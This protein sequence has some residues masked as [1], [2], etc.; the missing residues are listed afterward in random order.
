[1]SAS[2]VER[3]LYVI[4]S[5]YKGKSGLKSFEHDAD[6]VADH[7]R[8]ARARVAELQRQIDK[9]PNAA[10]ADL[11]SAQLSIAKRDA[12]K[13]ETEL[14]G[15]QRG[16]S[17]A[18]KALGLL[19]PVGQ[20]AAAGLTSAAVPVAAI[21]VAA[22]VA[23]KVIAKGI[24][25]FVAGAEAVE[26]YQRATGASA[27]ESSRLRVAFQDLGIDADTAQQ[28]L[29]RLNATIA[30]SPDKLAA[31]G[32]AVVRNRAGQVD[33]IA[34]L[35]S[36]ADAYRATE[37]PARRAAIVQAAF[38]RGGQALTPILA[39]NREELAALFH[40]ADRNG[41]VFSQKDIDE[42]N[43]FKVASRELHESMQGLGITLGRAVLPV[44][45]DVVNIMT[46]GARET[47]HLL[48]HLGGLGGVLHTLIA[49]LRA[50]SGDM[51]YVAK[52]EKQ[53]A[54]A[55]AAEEDAARAAIQAAIDEAAALDELATKQLAAAQATLT[56]SRNQLS[57]ERASLSV[58]QAQQQLS[59][60][61][62]QA[63]QRAR[64]LS[65]A[66]ERVVDARQRLAAATE[67][68][69]GKQREYDRIVKGFG[70]DSRE[71]A[72]AQRELT[73]AT[74]AAQGASLDLADARERAAD[75]LAAYN[76]ARSEYG[77]TSREAID[78]QRGFERAQLDVALASERNTD[79]QGAAND[80]GKALND[81]V[82]GTGPASQKAKDALAALTDA[83]KA[84]R[85][86][87]RG[88]RDAERAVTDAHN[89]GAGAAM[90]RRAAELAL[91]EAYISQ[92]DTYVALARSVA[93]QAKAM[94]EA[95]GETFTAV[96][97]NERFVRTLAD[98]TKGAP[99]AR[100][101]LKSF[102]DLLAKPPMGPIAAQDAAANA[103]YAAHVSDRL[104]GFGSG[105]PLAIVVPVTLNGKVIAEAIAPDVTAIQRRLA[106]R[107]AASS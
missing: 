97:Y 5:E 13:L 19:G 102:F 47:N 56:G 54:D 85:D 91:R 94:A 23:I 39:K 55:Q 26:K 33:T 75:A 27:E 101:A 30:G 99:A 29:V 73:D 105:G 77:A 18:A 63:A 15:L 49:P 68:T 66:E 76:E 6:D 79:A 83:Q 25:T 8:L 38:G 35:Q 14:A 72:A 3:L 16:S 45:T 50:V 42:A 104:S 31:L 86:A 52:I 80:A 89:A 32:I 78:A 10:N 71:A 84:E 69:A 82:N 57:L 60:L 58:A 62:D 21:A 81:T 67:T 2:V 40:A 41:Q 100:D 34:T 107:G 9:K 44:L 11:K 48:K 28:G 22:G 64:A 17:G 53:L 43:Q 103:A 36:V 87:A 93:D 12:A 4:E 88:V 70:A 96:Q 106:G 61:S 24:E 46:A 92:Q 90:A 20:E 74:Y 37:D 59:D 65:D 95:N 51:A 1:M 7:A 98:L